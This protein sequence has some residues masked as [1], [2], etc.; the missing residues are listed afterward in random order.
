MSK[1][2]L[3]NSIKAVKAIAPVVVTDTTAQVSSIID[4]AG[5]ESVE[6]LI[7]TGTLADSDATFAVLVEDGDDASLTD[8][9]EVT[10]AQFLLG[11]EAIANFDKDSDNKVIKIGYVGP[12]RY[13]RLT[14]TPALNSGNAPLAAIAVLGQPRSLP[15]STQEV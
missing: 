2:D 6:F 15:Q 12:K 8:A 9:A 11:T 4:R 3:H 10:N 7:V 13:V 14:V 1:S 5:F